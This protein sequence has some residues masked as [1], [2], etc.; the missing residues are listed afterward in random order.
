MS[1]GRS[2]IGGVHVFMMVYLAICSVLLEHISY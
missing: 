1:C 2:C